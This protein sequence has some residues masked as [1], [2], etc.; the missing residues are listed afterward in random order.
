MNT[1][2]K[3][4]YL[5][6]ID[7]RNQKSIDWSIVGPRDEARKAEVLKILEEQNDLVAEDYHHA[8]LI[9]QHGDF[10]ED[11]KKAHECAAKAVEMGDDSSRWLFAASWDR[12]QL[13]IGKPQRYGTQFIEE[14]SEWKL[15]RP[16]EKDFPDTERIKMDVPPLHQ[17][18][19]EFK[20]KYRI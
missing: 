11:Y 12:W 8:A 1:R 17:A 15:A 13:S 20:K 7:D 9:L 5:Q 19:H 3:E 18:L 2:L 6:D 16:I 10:P 4:L 14:D